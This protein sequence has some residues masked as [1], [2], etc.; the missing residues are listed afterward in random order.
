MMLDAL[1][2]AFA[3]LPFVMTL[4]N[5]WRFTTP[6]PAAEVHAVSVLIPARNEERNIG[7]A[8]ACVL[9]S[10]GVLLELIVLDDGSTDRMPAIL[11]GIAD[12]RLRVIRLPPLPVGWTGKQR[13]CAHGAT[14]ASHDLLVF[15]DADVRLTPDALRRICGFMVRGGLGLAS[16]F[17]RQTHTGLTDGLVVPL[18]HF[19]LLGYLPFRV[20][21]RLMLPALGAGCGQL[22][23]ATREAYRTSGG[24]AAVPQTMHDG[25]T[26]PRLF[27][28]A[29]YRTDI[30]DASRIAAC[31]MYETARETLEGLLKNAREG[32]A[33]PV[34]LPIWTALL[35]LGHLLPLALVL[36]SPS[37]LAW[38]AFLLSL[39]T[40]LVLVLRFRALLWSA[41]LHPAGVALLLAIQWVAL[42]RQ[43]VGAR[44]TWRGRSYPA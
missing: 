41:L 44:T 34:A 7:E 38:A 42:L 21:R 5:L 4:D 40:R 27:R 9:R 12:P 24:H 20:M 17:P 29:G 36:L 37:P 25:L 15:V 30:F 32:M 14:E 26:L 16:G 1:C 2:C 10:E 3:A 43:V 31:R 39:A 6:E 18:I 22:I 19:L 28:A 33:K 23:A 35:G 11:A 13:A 8:C